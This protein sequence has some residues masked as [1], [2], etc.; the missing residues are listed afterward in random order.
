LSEEKY[1]SVVERA[2]DGVAII[3]DGIVKYVNTRAMEMTGYSLQQVIDTPFAN[4]IHPDE[5]DEALDYYDR[6]LQG[7]D[8]PTLYQ[9]KLR[10][11]DGRKLPTEINGTLIIYEDRPAYLFIIRDVT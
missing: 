6:R 8:V 1:R 9:R 11:K 3:Q 5:L 2:S 10:H 4:Y 7:H